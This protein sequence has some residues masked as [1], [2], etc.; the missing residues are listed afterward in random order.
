MIV[1]R[2]TGKPP[3]DL[4]GP[5]HEQ[6]IEQARKLYSGSFTV[7]TVENDPVCGLFVEGTEHMII[8]MRAEWR[9]L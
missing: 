1:H 7:V 5:V 6:I 3:T 9:W 8:K 4:F 2:A